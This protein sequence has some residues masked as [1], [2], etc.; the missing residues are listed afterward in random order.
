[1]RHHEGKSDG[2]AELHGIVIDLPKFLVVII[3][4]HTALCSDGLNTM[5]TQ[6]LIP[7]QLACTFSHE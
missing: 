3:E 1:M 4:Y 5:V 6:K 2:V 7:V